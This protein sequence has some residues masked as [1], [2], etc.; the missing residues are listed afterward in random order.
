MNVNEYASEP[1]RYW[2]IFTATGAVSDYLK[3]RSCS[4]MQ[5]EDASGKTV[6]TENLHD[7]TGEIKSAGTHKFAACARK[8]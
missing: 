5:R 8:E 1:D 6:M 3:Y 4:D 2:N 7:V